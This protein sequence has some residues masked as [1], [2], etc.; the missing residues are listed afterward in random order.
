[1]PDGASMQVVNGEVFAFT[2][3]QSVAG[4]RQINTDKRGYSIRK[5]AGGVYEER[6]L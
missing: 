6:S 3:V 2:V 4:L 1:M 5:K